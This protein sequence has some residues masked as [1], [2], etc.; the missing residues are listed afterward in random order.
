M[1]MV[2]LEALVYVASVQLFGEAL[3]FG[4]IPQLGRQPHAKLDCSW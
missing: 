3:E 1:T 2:T 4:C